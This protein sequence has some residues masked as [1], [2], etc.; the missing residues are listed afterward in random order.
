[1]SMRELE[2]ALALVGEQEGASFAGPRGEYLA[3]AEQAL[4]HPLPPTYRRFVEELGAGDVAGVEVYGVLDGD[5]ANSGIPDATWFTLRERED[6]DMPEGLVAV[7]Q[8]VDGFYAC[9]DTRGVAA[10]DEAPVVAWF[11][12]EPADHLADDFGSFLL[13]ELEAAL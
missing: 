6:A 2:R 7:M 11:E 5:F 13:A 1:M 12:G 10:G 4:G 9:L 8:D 3:A